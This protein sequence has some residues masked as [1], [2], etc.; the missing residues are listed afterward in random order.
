M[1]REKKR[2]GTSSADFFSGVSDP[3][4][5]SKKGEKRIFSSKPFHLVIHDLLPKDFWQ[6]NNIWNNLISNNIARAK[7]R[8]M[9]V[10]SVRRGSL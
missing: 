8:S 10:C 1:D 7:P 9:V 3:A 6:T 5:K 4:V 2:R